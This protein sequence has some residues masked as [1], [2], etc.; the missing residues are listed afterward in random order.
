MRKGRVMFDVESINWDVS[1]VTIY[2][3][4]DKSA[5]ILIQKRETCGH[6]VDSFL[7]GSL[8]PGSDRCT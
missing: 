3:A 8:A 1:Q 5:Q 2:T 6:T 4:D 7:H